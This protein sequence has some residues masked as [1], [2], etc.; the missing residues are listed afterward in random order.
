VD[1][2]AIFLL[3][4]LEWEVRVL[5]YNRLPNDSVRETQ[6]TKDTVDYGSALRK[7]RNVL[8]SSRE[9]G[10]YASLIFMQ[11]NSD[12]VFCEPVNL[13]GSFDKDTLPE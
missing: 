13:D 8:S 4:L 7:N 10:L 2:W 11:K 12:D 6:H 9:C 1:F 5:W 3:L